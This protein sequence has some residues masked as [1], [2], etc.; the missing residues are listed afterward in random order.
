MG[1]LAFVVA[2][3]GVIKLPD[4]YS[5][6]SAVTTASGLGL[7]LIIAG[8]FLQHPSLSNGI[9]AGLAIVINLATSAVGGHAIAR[10]GYLTG[11]PRARMQYDD[12]ADDIRN[13]A[14]ERRCGS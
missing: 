6:I 9:K 2:A 12:L 3:I 5:R 1:V 7:A 11:S 4:M 10:A 14:G 13:S 8:V